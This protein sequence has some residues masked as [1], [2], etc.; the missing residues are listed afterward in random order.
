[1]KCPHC[2]YEDSKVIDS[3]PVDENSSIKRRRECLSCCAR[4][5]TFETVETIQ[6]MVVKKDGSR[7]YFDKAKLTN[8]IIKACQ[9]RP[10]NAMQIANKV[11]AEILN[12][13]RTEIS[14]T[15]I[16]EITMNE[17]I[18]ADDVAYIRFASI[19]KDFTD[20][21]TFLEELQKISKN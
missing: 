1:M 21:E 12:S 10:V 9:K 14:S 20:V 18:K 2:G 13:L 17:L 4:F 5:T 3:R 16:G 19:Y 8:G 6:P 7:E 11:E 15:E